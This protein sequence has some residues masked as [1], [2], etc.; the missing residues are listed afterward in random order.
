VGST[1]FAEE[2]METITKI[3]DFTRS[4]AWLFVSLYLA[5]PEGGKI[6]LKNIISVGDYLYKAIFNID[7]L[8]S[9]F[10]K[11]IDRGIIMV[12]N[13]E[14][15]YS[16]LGRLIINQYENIEGGLS[17][18]EK[19]EHVE[20]YLNEIDSLRDPEPLCEYMLNYYK[21]TYNTDYNPE[22]KRKSFWNIFITDAESNVS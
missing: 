5:Y 4:D 8:L 2:A 9:G 14:F 1:V 22:K 20:E 7:E 17:H 11:F 16:E 6:D 12:D 21:A 10:R 18:F 13:L 19:I 3:K 15:E